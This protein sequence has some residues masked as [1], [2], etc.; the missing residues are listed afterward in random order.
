MDPRTLDNETTD[1][2]G[3]HGYYARI[4][5]QRSIAPTKHH[6]SYFSLVDDNPPTLEGRPPASQAAEGHDIHGHVRV[7]FTQYDKRVIDEQSHS[8]AHGPPFSY[9]L[10]AGKN[11]RQM[12]IEAG[13]IPDPDD[14]ESVARFAAA[15]AEEAARLSGKVKKK[16]MA[17]LGGAEQAAA[18]LAALDEKGTQHSQKVPPISSLY[19]SS[20]AR[21]LAKG[22]DDPLQVEVVWSRLQIP[23]VQ[24]HEPLSILCDENDSIADFKQR[25]YLRQQMLFAAGTTVLQPDRMLLFL[26]S[27]RSA[28]AAITPPPTHLCSRT[29]PASRPCRAQTLAQLAGTK[30]NRFVACQLED[31][32]TLGHYGILRRNLSNN[33]VKRL[34][35]RPDM[36]AIVVMVDQKILTPDMKA[37]IE[38][39]KND[40]QI[41]GDGVECYRNI[42]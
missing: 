4:A 29:F 34:N 35:K 10:K 28:G 22:A 13:M 26:R 12:K 32:Y 3:G 8:A 16:N 23:G 25:I 6:G 38:R 42:M 17:E 15:A 39:A 1:K 9:R 19:H 20:V 33:Y 14:E 30:L 27:V 21:R 18:A 7:N 24:G 5:R 11:L 31:E 37:R 2:L 40:I 36:A 41:D